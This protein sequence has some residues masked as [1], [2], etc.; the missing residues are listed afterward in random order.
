MCPDFDCVSCNLQMSLKGTLGFI[1]AT[2]G[3]NLYWEENL[4][5]RA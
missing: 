4:P 5:L 1:T 2:E 3:A